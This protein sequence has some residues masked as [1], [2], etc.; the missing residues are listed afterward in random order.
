MAFPRSS[1]L[2]AV[3]VKGNGRAT[4]AADG[5]TKGFRASTA[6]TRASFEKPGVGLDSAEKLF[7]QVIIAGNRA[8]IYRLLCGSFESHQEIRVVF[9]DGQKLTR[10]RN[11]RAE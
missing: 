3:E 7:D 2:S 11:A 9:G 5:T 1:P 8:A 6:G 10:D 4:L